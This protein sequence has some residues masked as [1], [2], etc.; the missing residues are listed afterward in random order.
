MW[1]LIITFLS[2]RDPT[3]VGSFSVDIESVA[4]SSKASCE[5]AKASYLAEMKPTLDLLNSAIAAE[6]E[7]GNLRG[8]NAV[9]VSIICVAQ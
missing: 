5:A 6:K 4:F 7:M 1:L 2:Y 3:A 8:P 9:N